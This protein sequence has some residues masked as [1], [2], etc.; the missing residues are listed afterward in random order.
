[1]WSGIPVSLRIFHSCDP[2][3]DSSVVSEAEID[4]FWG[5]GGNSLAFF[6][7]KLKTYK[8]FNV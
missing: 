4:F 8:I 1:M 6:P 5:G 7:L 3:K 2:N